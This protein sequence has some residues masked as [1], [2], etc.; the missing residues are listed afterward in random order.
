MC[1]VE[2]YFLIYWNDEDGV[3]I[4][5][6]GELAEVEGDRKVGDTCTVKFGSKS[7]SG[8]IAFFG[9]STFTVLQ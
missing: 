2:F 8:Q 9:K 3:S 1:A 7:Y 6:E 5:H 4:H